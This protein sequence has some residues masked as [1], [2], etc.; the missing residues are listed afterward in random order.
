MADVSQARMLD[1]IIAQLSAL[2][3][4]LEAVI[5]LRSKGE[6]DDSLADLEI[7]KI[8]ARKRDLLNEMRVVILTSQVSP[9]PS[10]EEVA[11]LRQR[12]SELRNRNV[13][14]AAIQDIVG[15]AFNIAAAF[16]SA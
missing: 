1:R 3:V 16:R 5:T 13:T 14:A 11:K 9:A 12:V 10:D 6:M 4:A 7:L 2:Q 8:E 15:E